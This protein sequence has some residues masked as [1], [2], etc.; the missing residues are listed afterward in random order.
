MSTDLSSIKLAQIKT[1]IENDRDHRL[2]K[3]GVHQYVDLVVSAL[4][5]LY[6]WNSLR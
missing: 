4:L 1:R 5:D 2:L 6:D 3:I